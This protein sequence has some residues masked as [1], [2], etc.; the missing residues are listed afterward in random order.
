MLGEFLACR[1]AYRTYTS[2]Y[3]HNTRIYVYVRTVLST[4]DSNRKIG[5]A[6]CSVWGFMKPLFI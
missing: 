6:L 4:T 5:Y 2:S 1:V 3:F